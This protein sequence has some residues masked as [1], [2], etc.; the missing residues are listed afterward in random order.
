LAAVV[1]TLTTLDVAHRGLLTGFDH[2]VSRAMLRL[3]IDHRLGLKILVYP[4][5]LFGQRFPVLLITIPTICYLVWRGRSV[6][7]A[8]RY[9]VALVAL[10]VA[11]YALKDG[12][13][14]TAPPVDTIHTSA[15]ASF[16]S[17]HLANAILVWGLAWWCARAL[18]PH[19]RLTDALRA[20]WIVGP[21][22]VIVGMTLLDYHWISDFIAGACIGAILLA[23]VTTAGWGRIAAPID[24][25]VW[26]VRAA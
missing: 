23:G 8:I 4:L 21:I 9:G 14:R 22:C 2:R 19:A 11:V 24:R 5:T 7:P 18:Q 16:P 17:G 20:T 3:G 26:R 12:L 25:L 13:R 1:L 6:E 10:E 15:G